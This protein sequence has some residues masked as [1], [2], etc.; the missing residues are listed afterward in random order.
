[1]HQK[2]TPDKR[3]SPFLK[4]DVEQSVPGRFEAQATK[5]ADQIAVKD[6]QG[7][8]TYGEFNAFAN[9]IAHG[10]LA[11]RGIGSEQVVLFFEQGANFLAAIF[12]VLKTG[13]CYVPIDPSFPEAR[14]RYILEHSQACL[15]VTNTAN[16]TAA[17]S[18]VAAGDCD[19]EIVNIDELSAELSRENPSVEISPDAL[20]Y[21]IYT[22]GSTGKPKGVFQNHRN[23]LHNARNQIN[24]FHLGVGDRMPLVHSC[25]V[26]GAV[27]VIYN[28]LLSGTS[29]Y[30]FDV[31]AEGLNALRDLLIRE[32]ITAFHAVATLFRHFAEIFQAGDDF[33]QLRLVILGGE[34]MSRKDVEFYKQHFP[35]NCLLCTG[36]GST[37]AGTIRI[38]VLNKEIEI[39]TGNVPPGYAVEGID[40]LLWDEQGNE[41]SPG[42]VGEIV[43]QSEYLAL[44]YW[45][46]GESAGE[47]AG[48]AAK[49]QTNE[50][51]NEQANEQVFVPIAPGSRVRRFRT[52]DLGR[53]LPDGCLVHM[54]RKDF[55]VK[56]RGFRVNVAEI[57]AALMDSE[58]LKETVV[59]GRER[60][61]GEIVLVAYVVPRGQGEVA[62]EDRA[63]FESQTVDGLRG[64]V[65][66]K[67]PDY[68]MPSTFV[69]LAALPQTPNDK[70]DR[71]ALPEPPAPQPTTGV[72]FVPPKTPTQKTLATI[73]QTV[74]NLPQVGIADNFFELGGHSLLAAQVVARVQT[75]CRVDISLAVMFETPTIEGIAIAI[76]RAIDQAIDQATDRAAEPGS[77]SFA[78]T[79]ISRRS[80]AEAA[81][82]SFA[83]QR[84]WFLQQLEP[85]SHAYHVTRTL[86]LSGVLDVDALQRAFVTILK[87]H[88]SLRTVFV[89]VEGVPQQRVLPASGAEVNAFE[90]AFVDLSEQGER[91]NEAV[92]R[93]RLQAGTEQSF[94]LTCDLLLRGHLIRLSE[95]SHVLQIVMHHIASDGW[96]IR[97]FR[98]ELSALYQAYTQAQ[99]SPLVALP[100]QYADFSVWQRQ[101]LAGEMLETQM[102]YWRQQLAGQPPLIALLT[103]RP[104]P[105]QPTYRGDWQTFTL[106]KSVT[107]RLRNLSQE[108][109]TTLFMTLL[110]AFNV[111]LY[112]YTR[113]ADIVVGSPIANRN[114][115]ELEG[116][117]GFFANTLALRTDLSGAPSFVDL[118]GRVRQ[119]ALDAYT[120]QNLPFEKLVEA[121]QPE[122]NLGYS[123]IF[124]VFFALQNSPSSAQA[125]VD[126]KIQAEPARH[127]M[128]KFDLTLSLRECVDTEGVQTGELA[129][130]FKYS[131]DLFD[132]ATIA[133]MVEHFQILLAGLVACPA[134]PIDTVSMLSADERQ[135]LLFDWNETE[136]AYEKSL[137]VHE[138]FEAQVEKTPDAIALVYKDQQLTYRELNSRANQLAHRLRR[139]GV[140]AETLV[141]LCVVRS[142]DTIVGILGILKAGGAYV[143]LDFNYPQ[144]RLV[145]IVDD[146]RL[147]VLVTQ[148]QFE[149][150]WVQKDLKTIFLDESYSSFSANLPS[151]TCSENLAYVIYTSG[152]TGKP[153]GVMI[154]HDSVSN[155]S[156]ALSQAIEPYAQ[157]VSLNVSMNGSFAFDTSVK[158]IVQLLHG[159]TLNIIPE[160]IRVDGAALLSHLQQH[161]IEVFDSTP[162]QLNLLLS[163]G[164]LESEFPKCVLL[165]GEPI[166]EATWQ[167]LRA[168]KDTHFYNVYGPTECTVDATIHS[169]KQA[170]AEPTIGRPIANVSAYVLDDQLNPVPVNV[171]GELH[172][173]G[174][175][176]ARGYLNQPE[177]ISEKFVASPF[178]EGRLYKTG[179]LARY[180]VDG[181]IEYLGRVDQQV[182]LRGFRIELG[183]IEALLLQQ[184]AVQQAAVI[185]REDRPGD[186]QL[187]AYAVPESDALLK[188]DELRR[189]LQEQLPQYMLP[190]AFVMLAELPLTPN[191]K[192]DVRSLPIPER[193]N[194]T[195]ELVEPETLTEKLLVQI[196]GSI[197]G[198]AEIGIH[199]TFFELGGH[200]LL[201]AQVISRIRLRMMLD[202]PLRSLFEHPTI[203]ELA[204]FIDDA[205]AQPTGGEI[206][207]SKA[208]VKRA[209]PAIA[210][211]KETISPPLSFAQQRLWFLQQLEPAGSRYHI[212]WAQ[213][214]EGPLQ[215]EA[216]RQ[217]LQAIVQRH[218]ALR[219]SFVAVEGVPQQV[220]L[221]ADIFDLQVVDLGSEAKNQQTQLLNSLLT[222]SAHKPF[223]LVTDL[224]LR[225]TLIRLDE[226]THV[227]QVVV[228]HIAT[229]GWSMAVF[230]REL[231]ALYGTYALGQVDPLPALPIQYGDFAVWQREWLAGEV[232]A[233]QLDYWTQQLQGAPAL[234]VLPT[235]YPRPTHPSYEGARTTFVVSEGVVRS[236]NALSQQNNATLFMT[237]FAAFNT[238]LYRYTQQDDIV[239][240]SPIAN[241]DRPELE[242]LIGFFTNTLALRT[243]LSGQPSF[244]ELLKRVRQVSL[245]AYTHQ[246][247]P[248]EKLVEE[249]QPERSLSYSP[250]FQVLFVLQN[251]AQIDQPFSGL[252]CYPHPVENETAKFDLTLTMQVSEGEL[253]GTFKYNT[254]LFER[255]TIERMAK[256]FKTLLASIA[257]YPSQSIAKL[258][259]LE[260]AEQHQL[261]SQWNDTQVESWPYQ[262]IQAMFEAQVE[263]TPNA[264]ALTY[265]GDCELQQLTYRELNSKA[266]QLA[267]YLQDN[268]VEPEVLVGLCVPRSLDMI[269]GLLGIL[270]SG[271]AYVPLDPV[272]PQERLDYMLADSQANI[273]VTAETVQSVLDNEQYSV[274]NPVR[275]SK[276]NNLAYVLYT[277]GSTGQPKGV[278]IEHRQLLN[279]TQGIVAKLNLSTGAS[280]AT[281]ST[282]AADLGNT[283]IFASLATGGCLHVISQER[284]T[285]PDALADYFIQHKIDCLKIVPSHLAALLTAQQP[286]KVLPRQRL[287]LGGEACTWDLVEQIQSLAPECTVFNHYGPTET[288]VGVATCELKRE[289]WKGTATVPPIGDPLANAQLYLLDP[290]RQLVPVGTVGEVYIG[291]AG[292]ARGYFNRPVLTSEKFIDNPFAETYDVSPRLYKTGDLGRRLSDGSIEL[293]GRIDD[294]IKIRGNRIE[295][296]EIQ[297]ALAGHLQVQQCVVLVREDTLGE[298]CL[299]AYVVADGETDGQA[300]RDFLQQTL[301]TYMIPGAFVA[302]A[303]L[304]LTPNG[305][306]D[307]KA[308]AKLDYAPT[309]A[310]QGAYAA[311]ETPLEYKI[312]KI[313]ADVLKL[314][315]ISIKD[316]FFDLGGH[317][318]LAM[319]LVSQLQTQLGQTIPLS[320]LF[321]APTV[322][323]LAIAL[324]KK[325][326]SNTSGD[327]PKSLMTLQT[328]SARRSPIF[329]VHPVGGSVMCYQELARQ[330]G[331]DQPFYALQSKGLD[332]AASGSVMTAPQMPDSLQAM[333]RRYIE[334]IR[335]V[336]PEGPYALGGWSMG[337]VVA[338]EMAQQLKAQG[339]TISALILIDSHAP[340]ARKRTESDEVLLM[341]FA[342]H[343]ALSETHSLSTLAQLELLKQSLKSQPFAEQLT[344]LLSGLKQLKIVPGDLSKENLQQLFSVFKGN[345]RAVN[346]YRPK[347]YAGPVGLFTCQEPVSKASQKQSAQTA[348]WRALAGKAL[349]VKELPGNHF[350]VLRNPSVVVIANR[351]KKVA[352]LPKPSG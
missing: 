52:G 111:L 5:Y 316:N 37:E 264:I 83:Q 223:D 36:L 222:Q 137:C 221:S 183:E 303:A 80:S 227:L 3:F 327:T 40:V 82:L 85:E 84:L 212:N 138:L 175:G 182:K 273:L 215:V 24:A 134:Q 287:L 334:E 45:R 76:D 185:V 131:T 231:S 65:K 150:D 93:S 160:E 55:Q 293:V 268:G 259:L 145:Q 299:V 169:L 104:R 188:V 78:I 167:V 94:D 97:V 117:I 126:L 288:T 267:H 203:A 38:F 153:K 42:D 275:N 274:T 13:K 75:I 135:R 338:F 281:V 318:L 276:S 216:L 101:W 165:G 260:S 29:L 88:E 271:G 158:Q 69:F 15:V 90:L 62:A 302:I 26:M 98:Q 309:K 128:A 4:A 209:L 226:Q 295:L 139:D 162:S 294:Q 228:H 213:R 265:Q 56:I 291:G 58:Q 154:Q 289:R 95:Q 246:N 151:L 234:L 115:P 70:L 176:V 96:S 225:A 28:A 64:V 46:R 120:H 217:A 6:R 149:R 25:S 166:N 256:H 199:D 351:L 211:R 272:L 239:M 249:L 220:L 73:W 191:G 320:V 92:L 253:K 107:D 186:R 346:N 39:T 284:I 349:T 68:M 341:R 1:M 237:L 332:G 301:P 159:H 306:I 86:R 181:S 250:L 218:E 229:D 348:F 206:F 9:R 207:A 147:T 47:D 184:K 17:Q 296:G 148:K 319:H 328:G 282:L 214:L 11:E 99:P 144:E 187:V 33:S 41:V 200:S 192:V 22:S 72:D 219:T 336:Q 79:P 311:P 269:I 345:F 208:K 81:S 43:L 190:S 313:W 347:P 193:D 7:C 290:H 87:R 205:I 49:R 108:N 326:P 124:Q 317:S 337:G 315:A 248:F 241:R 123:P 258:P 352:T 244:V 50:Q 240:G 112:R 8:F 329:F 204:G 168:A 340:S 350:T 114:R 19:C 110:A 242:D 330:L 67:L 106:S 310:N 285:Q 60:P 321:Q 35:D 233:S 202:V 30:P 34:A 77:A 261:L 2:I 164:L 31:K 344:G 23:L 270:K 57:E 232:L 66:A 263:K 32:K 238:L 140:V 325:A 21:I 314:E 163:A 129:G 109:S 51:A 308:L 283:V 105:A 298:K 130:T 278:A 136:A 102:S 201:A 59:V 322:E 255:S 16:L 323:Q 121:L 179:D 156:S 251:E 27:R 247:L 61:S 196:W 127:E 194:R 118:L 133:R 48:E 195:I 210:P 312:A 280:F 262:S 152:S 236:L 292:L 243:D 146:A 12:G 103:D 18:L 304:P 230:R 119:T 125:L 20:A 132:A 171:S 178:G 324:Q 10:V 44:G 116:M 224:M 339:E 14:N 143:P 71:R 343:L 54:G 100:I 331:S 254:D 177:L 307:R 53:F 89:E 63:A 197:L 173:G 91:E 180:K 257:A 266:N 286:Q 198:L 189:A 122:R 141:G 305:K 333:A 335:T 142:L 279:Y 161:Q 155:L 277:S 297:S 74:L 245:D 172:I 235:D 342:K 113:Q 174:A 300:Y 157:S 252:T 170:T